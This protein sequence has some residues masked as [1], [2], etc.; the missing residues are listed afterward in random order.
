MLTEDGFAAPVGGAI[1][2]VDIESGLRRARLAFLALAGTGEEPDAVIRDETAVREASPADRIP[3]DRDVPAG[4]TWTEEPTERTSGTYPTPTRTVFWMGGSSLVI[5]GPSVEYEHAIHIDRTRYLI[6]GWRFAEHGNILG[7]LM[8]DVRAEGI[9]IIDRLA[10]TTSDPRGSLLIQL[11]KGGVRIGLRPPPGE[12]GERDL[13]QV[14]ARD[15]SVDTEAMRTLSFAP[16]DLD[17]DGLWEVT[18]HLGWITPRPGVAT[19]IV[20]SEDGFE[21]P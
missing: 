6:L 8:L 18:Y 12:P 2:V 20:A 11:V 14:S 7:A 17:G 15:I 13:W 5:R 9:E 16:I 19:W 4:F 21:L 3:Q 1:A 10:V